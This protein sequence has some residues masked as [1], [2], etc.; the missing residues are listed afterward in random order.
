M[1]SLCFLMIYGY[2]I[3]VPEAKTRSFLFFSVIETT[4]SAREAARQQRRKFQGI[5]KKEIADQQQMK[6]VRNIGYFYFL[7]QNEI[8][9][10]SKIYFES[11]MLTISL[12]NSILLIFIEFISLLLLYPA[13]WRYVEMFP[14]LIP[15]ENILENF[16]HLPLIKRVEK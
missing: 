5:G 6:T 14:S 8:S 13:R 11:D 9:S 4:K 15:K 7:G 10:Y 12:K 3:T 16:G 1:I 2:T